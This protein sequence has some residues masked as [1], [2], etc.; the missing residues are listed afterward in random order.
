[1]PRLS[2]C[3]IVRNEEVML[4]A[5]LESVKGLVDEIVV[6]DTGSTDRTLELVRQAGAT[7]VE[8]PWADD[9]SAPR[10]AALAHAHGDFVLQLDADE[11]LS[12]AA[13]AVVKQA[14]RQ[15]DFDC[16]FLPLHNAT[17]LD[18]PLLEVVNGRAR[19]GEAIRLPRLFRR[20]RDLHYEGVIHESITTWLMAGGR[21]SR[22]LDADIIHLG[23]VAEV[24]N[25]RDKQQRNLALLK[26]RC[27]QE[28]TDL[29]ARGYLAYELMLDGKSTEARAAVDEGWALRASS[30]SFRSLQRLAVTRALVYLERRELETA[31]QAIDEGEKV[32]GPQ[33]EFDFCRG[34]IL[35]S[36][37][38]RASG[39]E[40]DDLLAAADRQYAAALA[41]RS[42]VVLE[43][44]LFGVDSWVSGFRRVE[45]A[46]ARERYEEALAHAEVA[47]QGQREQDVFLL[48]RA[49]ALV[50]L[51]RI[52][53]ALQQLAPLLVDKPDAWCVAARAA[54]TQGALSD[55]AL[56][57][58]RALVCEAAGFSNLRL[59]SLK[60]QLVQA[61]A[62]YQ[63]QRT[64]TTGPIGAL[65]CLLDGKALAGDS[66]MPSLADVRRVAANLARVGKA[67]ALLTL[68]E[69]PA[70]TLLPG[71]Q[72]CLEEVL[73]AQG[74]EL[75]ETPT[76]TGG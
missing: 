64:S 15:D 41:K 16:A 6:V 58:N 7:L 24:R 51:G 33:A 44:T 55:M 59:A 52:D 69:G 13:H 47:L 17:R 62:L 37:A 10:N 28:P 22:L 61:T 25:A 34:R 30:P 23:Y 20:T 54:E 53:E 76:P 1:M 31:T 19:A 49:E 12:P 40:R 29:T 66:T 27:A 3:L 39:A 71:L 50:G 8:L 35:E 73:R 60:L 65:A 68:L 38:E 5:C 11:R 45:V 21:R 14:L 32:N 36:R 67:Q 57:L 26:K 2:L 4:P 18:A 75:E 74:F 46:L 63:G 70:K 48:A 72:A 42:D 9:F 43:R 56:F